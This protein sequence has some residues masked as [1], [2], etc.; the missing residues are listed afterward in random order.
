MIWLRI[1]LFRNFG[2]SLMMMIV[3]CTVLSA[4]YK[5]EGHFHDDDGNPSKRYFFVTYYLP[6]NPTIVAFTQNPDEVKNN[7]LA[8]R[9]KGHF[10][11]YTDINANTQCDLLWIDSLGR[12]LEMLHHHPHLTAGASTVYTTMNLSNNGIDFQNIKLHLELLG[13]TLLTHWYW[14]NDRGYALF[15]KKEIFTGVMNSFSYNFPKPILPSP[16]PSCLTCFLKLPGKKSGTHQ[17]PGIDYIY[18]INLDERPEKFKQSQDELQKHGIDPYRFSAV[19]GWKLHPSTLNQIGVNFPEGSL[20]DTFF[21]TRYLNIDGERFL[22]NEMISENK[23]RYFCLGISPGAIG[24]I[25]SHLSILQDAVLSNYQTIWI[26]EDDVAVKEDPH[27]ISQLIQQLDQADPDWDIFFTDVDTINDQG[28]RVP[29]RA[30]AARPNASTLP[31]FHYFR[32]FYAVSPRLQRTGMRYGAYSMIVRRKGM[33]KILNYFKEYGVYLPYDMDIWFVPDLK[34]YTPTT[35]IVTHRIGA[36]S[37][38][39]DSNYERN[40]Q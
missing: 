29:C 40:K 14:E 30:L 25:L 10:V 12:E 36:L 5:K 32:L 15:V 11:K 27:Q 1:D 20:H 9:P 8:W 28:H 24:I 39:G 31:L 22:H 3:L 13:F 7:C 2:R 33:E 19:N 17:M 38:N 35:D 23:Q 21:A 26:M 16:S 18:M 6:Y 34:A 4:A 37:D